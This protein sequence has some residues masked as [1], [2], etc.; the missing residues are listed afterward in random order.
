MLL[1]L[2][3]AVIVFIK[4]NFDSILLLN[5]TLSFAITFLIVSGVSQFV[6]KDNVRFFLYA[7]IFIILFA[8]CNSYTNFLLF[9]LRRRNCNKGKTATARKVLH[10]LLRSM[11]AKVFSILS[12]ISC[13]NGSPSSNG[14]F[15]FKIT[16]RRL[17][18]A[19]CLS[20]ALLVR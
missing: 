18:I 1:F 9:N 8:Y 4:A 5:L 15:R 20:R 17:Y 14:M 19:L 10:G 16:R 6:T 12:T 7:A 2:L 3:S 13:V 11:C